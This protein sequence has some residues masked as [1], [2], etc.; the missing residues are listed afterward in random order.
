[1]RQKMAEQVLNHTQIGLLHQY[2]I[3]NSKKAFLSRWNCVRFLCLAAVR[4]RFSFLRDAEPADWF[5]SAGRS[6]SA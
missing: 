5:N 3:G 2:N 1:M 4:L 6:E